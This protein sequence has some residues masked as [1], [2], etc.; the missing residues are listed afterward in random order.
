MVRRRCGGHAPVSRRGDPRTPQLHEALYADRPD[1]VLY[2]IGGMAGPVAAEHWGVPAVQVSPSMVAWDT[3][4][5]D[6]AEV[7]E[8][9]IN[10]PG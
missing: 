5:Q 1:I 7:L 9:M 8:P 6:M 3:Y 10:S 4:H 2:D